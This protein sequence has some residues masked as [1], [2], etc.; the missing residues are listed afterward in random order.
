MKRRE[1]VGKHERLD[2]DSRPEDEHVLCLAQIKAADTT[3]KQVANR[4]VEE[5]PQDVDPRG[6]QAYPRGRCKGALKGVSRDSVAEMGQRV[7][8]EYSREKI[9]YVMVPAH[10]CSL[11]TARPPEEKV[12][13]T[14]DE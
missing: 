4:K 13:L 12:F 9:G 11:L 8:E 2:E 14:I 3:N 7:R 6:R 1:S 5:A 10:R